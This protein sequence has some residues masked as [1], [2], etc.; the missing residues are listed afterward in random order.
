MPF[1]DYCD[2]L[3]EDSNSWRLLIDRLLPEQRPISLRCLHNNI[4][5]ADERFT[6]LKQ[7]KWHRLDLRPE[8]DALWN[9][10]HDSTHRAIRSRSGRASPSV[11]RSR[12]RNSDPF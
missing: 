11:W 1:S 4:P 10:M 5:L 2:P 3:A 9:A 6:L 8:L 12:S 7:A